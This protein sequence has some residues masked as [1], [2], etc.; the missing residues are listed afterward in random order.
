VIAAN[1]AL[2]QVELEPGIGSPVLGKVLGL[3]NLRSWRVSD[4][5]L[6]WF[7]FERN[8]HLDV[9]RLLGERQD[10]SAILALVDSHQ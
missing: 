1:A 3:P 9:A 6:L 2:D 10:V 7:Y 5:P 8:D 4:F